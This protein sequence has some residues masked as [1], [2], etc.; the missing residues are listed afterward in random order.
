MGG[1]RHPP[2]L[3]AL[4]VQIHLIFPL[5][6]YW[7]KWSALFYLLPSEHVFLL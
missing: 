3:L 2:Q 6:S 5:T 1:G 7:L 4:F